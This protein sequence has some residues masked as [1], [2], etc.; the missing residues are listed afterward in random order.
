MTKQKIKVDIVTDINC[1]WC[2]IGEHRFNQAVAELKET[3]EF[4]ISIKPYELSPDAPAEGESKRDYF[5]RNYGPDGISRMASSSQ[6][7]AEMG[8]NEGIVFDFEKA[9]RIHNTFNAHRL[10]W[11]AG[12]YGVQQ[13][14]TQTLYRSNFT[15]G[16]NVND[17]ELL[18]RIGTTHGIPA[19]RLQ[20]FFE[21]EKGKAEVRQ[22]EHQSQQAGI[23]GV[24]AFILND[25]YLVSGA[26]PA[27]TFK[28]VFAQIAPAYEKIT[29]DG[30]SCEVGGDC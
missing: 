12:Q 4:E 5:L 18:L 15:E 26:Q 24:P 30:T 14:V 22:L 21:S 23:R 7:L 10:I 3:H 8:Q 16:Q 25:Q 28:Q 29:A 6:H 20:A 13:E 11:L 1:P 9:T 27:D 17:L 2:Y 19:E